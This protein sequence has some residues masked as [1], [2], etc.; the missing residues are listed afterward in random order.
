MTQSNSGVVITVIV[1]DT[2]AYHSD[3]LVGDIIKKLDERVIYG[4]RAMADALAGKDGEEVLLSIVRNGESMQKRI[5]LN[6]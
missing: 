2:P 3:L 5:K 1:N 6:Q 4:Q